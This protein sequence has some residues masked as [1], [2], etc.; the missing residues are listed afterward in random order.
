MRR[1]TAAPSSRLARLLERRGLGDGASAE[2]DTLATDEPLLA[3][4][5]AASVTSRVATGSRSGQRVLR[6]GDRIDAE[7]LP[8]L[9]GERCA[10]VG[11]VS[12]HANVAVP[13]HDRRRLERLCRLCRRLHKRHHADRGVMRT[14]RSRRSGER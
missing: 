7:D 10:S 11:G 14:S 12:V 9:Q 1:R 13:T 3:S 4:L 2:G 6:M 8:M 5:Y